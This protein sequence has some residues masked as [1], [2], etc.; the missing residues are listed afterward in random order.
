MPTKISRKILILA[1]NPKDTSPLRLDQ[2]V[3]E[4]DEGLR[5]VTQ[6]DQFDL[7]QRWAVRPRDIQRV[8]LDVEPQIVHFSGHGV[9][10]E[11]LV[12]EDDA[13]QARTVSSSALAELFRLFSKQVECVVLNA[14][15]SSP[16]AEVIA[17]HIPYVIGTNQAISD[18]ASIAFS[19]GFYDALAAG[20]PV[21]FAY[22]LGCNAIQLEGIDESLTPVLLKNSTLKE[23]SKVRYRVVLSGN[24]DE[25]SREELAA[26]V[27][28][29]QKISGDTSL[30][31]KNL[32]SGSIILELEGY[33]EG[34]RVIEAL[35]REG[36]LTEVLGLPITKVDYGISSCNSI[37]HP[38]EVFFS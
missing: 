30:E 33:E 1:A 29:L 16:Q 10:D 3:R 26:I 19:V 15:F 35:Y 2:E 21:E 5:R 24:T 12:F 18:R 9:F 11:G 14:C 31:L 22:E 4:I 23:G 6:R 36:K 27:E 34:Y 37:N 38:V 8:L 28:C 17:Q 13:G 25:V 32:L 20:Q 7:E